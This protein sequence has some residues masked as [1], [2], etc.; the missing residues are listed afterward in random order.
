MLYAT[1][2]CNKVNTNTNNNI[3]NN[4]HEYETVSLY[5]DIIPDNIYNNLIKN[6]TLLPKEQF[7]LAFIFQKN[8]INDLSDY[9]YRKILENNDC[10]KLKLQS[11]YNLGVLSTELLTRYYFF[12]KVIKLS[13]H[14]EN[15][16]NS[17]EN[18]ISNS[19][20]FLGKYLHGLIRN[21]NRT[22]NIN[23]VNKYYNLASDLENQNAINNLAVIYIEKDQ[24]EQA[25]VILKNSLNYGNDRDAAVL[26]FN[27]CWIYKN[28]FLHNKVLHEKYHKLAIKL[29]KNNK[30]IL[31][32]VEDAD[33]D[34]IIYS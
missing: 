30:I 23:V 34:L 22:I 5:R 2:D 6:I 1:T 24:P 3:H 26:S 16:S 25:I 8:K 20:F 11:L 29:A 14:V 32:M 4:I 17:E 31:Q 15:L 18:C 13:A 21:G 10:N 7:D 19:S 28:T 12:L 27:L 33:T 9:W